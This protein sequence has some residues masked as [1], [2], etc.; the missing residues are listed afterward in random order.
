LT[1]ACGFALFPSSAAAPGELVRAADAALYRAKA[2]G[3][4]DVAVVDERAGAEGASALQEALRRAVREAESDL[5]PSSDLTTGRMVGLQS[6]AHC[7]DATPAPVAPPASIPVLP[8]HLLRG[9]S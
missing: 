7:D 8:R 5:R 2:M 6:G 3:G 9:A 4:A 1:C